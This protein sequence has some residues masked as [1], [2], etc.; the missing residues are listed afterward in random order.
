MSLDTSFFASFISSVVAQ[1][2]V[3]RIR[4]SLLRDIHRLSGRYHGNAQVGETLYRLEQDVEH[5]AELSGDILPS[6]LQMVVV[7]VM[8]LVTMAVLN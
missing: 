5:V 2:L 8:V 6:T 3:F 4:V 1:K 7:G